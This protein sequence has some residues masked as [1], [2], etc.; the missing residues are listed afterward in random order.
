MRQ[1]IAG[2]WRQGCPSRFCPNPVENTYPFDNINASRYYRFVIKT[3]A[4]NETRRLFERERVRRVPSDLRKRAL[5]KLLIL[6]A[7]ESLE[8]LR[9]P[10]GNHLERLSGDR[11]GRHSIRVNEQWRICFRWS[12]GDALDGEVVDYHRG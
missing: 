8:D 5:N 7:A 6:D 10:P 11:E 1:G 3:F 9:R 4:D 2:A 12:G